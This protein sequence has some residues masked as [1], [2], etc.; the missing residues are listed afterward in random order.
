M[1]QSSSQTVTKI[2]IIRN[3]FSIN[4]H[5]LNKH[6]STT[7][8]VQHS[9]FFQPHNNAAIL[10][11]NVLLLMGQCAAHNNEGITLKYVHHL[12]LLPTTTSYMQP[13]NQGIIYCTKC[14]YQSSIVYH[15]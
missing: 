13:L 8:F 12:Y 1:K 6:L 14:V 7:Y 15:W 5:Y 11:R 9:K 2:W 4:L 3:Y 10:K